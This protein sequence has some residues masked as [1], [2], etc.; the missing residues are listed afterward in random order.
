MDNKERIY[1]EM[2]T[3]YGTISKEQ[4]EEFK[5]QLHGMVHWLL[6]YK[7]K[8]FEKLDDYFSSVLFKINGLN[9]VMNYPSNIMMLITTLE[10]A[11][12]ENQKDECDYNKYR[13]AILDAHSIIDKIGVTVSDEE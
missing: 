4:F 13:K 10:A 9:S 1:G 11:R 3:K 6:L 5:S 2:D 8:N 7:E 12:L